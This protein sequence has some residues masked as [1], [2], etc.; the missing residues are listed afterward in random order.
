[1]CIFNMHLDCLFPGT[2]SEKSE[3]YCIWNISLILF[4]D[5]STMT[6]LPS[7]PLPSVQH[8]H[9]H[10]HTHTQESPCTNNV[11]SPQTF[12]VLIMFQ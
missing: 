10:T 2:S 7:Y 9:T 12:K 4:S 1:M 8:T 11:F 5:L 3:K 6:S